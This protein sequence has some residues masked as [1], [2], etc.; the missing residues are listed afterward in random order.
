MVEAISK[1]EYSKFKENK[2]SLKDVLKLEESQGLNETIRHLRLFLETCDIFSLFTIVCPTD[3][4]L[5]VCTLKLHDGKPITYGLLTDY[6][7]VTPK[8]VALSTVWYN[9]YGYFND[10]QNNKHTLSRDMS[11]SL[12]HFK[13]HVQASLHTD[14]D[15]L[16]QQYP[17]IQRGGPFYFFLLMKELVLSNEK[18]YEALFSHV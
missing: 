11:W 1:N 7:A 9:K 10:N 12:L 16:L 18:I 13:Q 3:R 2:S 8:I 6:R 17:S 4:K 5:L 14:I 15:L